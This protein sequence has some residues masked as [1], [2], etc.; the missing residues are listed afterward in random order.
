[1]YT[2]ETGKQPIKQPPQ[3]N[4]PPPTTYKNGD[5]HS[6]P[7]LANILSISAGGGAPARSSRYSPSAPQAPA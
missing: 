1:M 5:S 4:S 7:P 6:E 2:K 3:I